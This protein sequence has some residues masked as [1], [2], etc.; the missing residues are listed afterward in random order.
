M[1]NTLKHYLIQYFNNYLN[2]RARLLI[3]IRTEITDNVEISPDKNVE[4]EET[5]PISESS[6]SKSEEFFLFSTILEASM[7]DKKLCD[8][9]VF[10]ELSMGNAGNS[11]DGQ[12]ESQYNNMSD[13]EE[14]L[15][16][17]LNILFRLPKIHYY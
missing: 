7:I 9:P 5:F 17:L 3:A 6:Y 16:K 11:L 10:F 4:L 14:E 15:G 12:N 1:N 13:E 8:R 2:Y